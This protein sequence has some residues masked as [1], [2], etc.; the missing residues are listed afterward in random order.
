MF[1]RIIETGPASAI[2][3]QSL[4]EITSTLEMTSL[5]GLGTGLGDIAKSAA[6]YY[7][8]ELKSCFR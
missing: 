2:E 6:R 1:R 4:I 7:A 3:R 5:C 8:E